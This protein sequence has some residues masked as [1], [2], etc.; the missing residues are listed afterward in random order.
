[1]GGV[2]LGVLQQRGLEVRAGLFGRSLG[3]E[4]RSQIPGVVQTL[5]FRVKEA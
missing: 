4:G 2:W 3:A 5:P 1:M